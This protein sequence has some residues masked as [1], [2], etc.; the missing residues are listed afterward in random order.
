MA[1]FFGDRWMS[2]NR[3]HCEMNDRH[4]AEEHSFAAY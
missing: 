4:M 3:I 1:R 2:A